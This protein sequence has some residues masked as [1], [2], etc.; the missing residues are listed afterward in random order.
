METFKIRDFTVE[1][2]D[3]Y[4]L[5]SCSEEGLLESLQ[6]YMQD[7]DLDLYWTDEE[8]DTIGRL[9]LD[10]KYESKCSIFLDV[11]D[12]KNVSDQEIS[13]IHLLGDNLDD[14]LKTLR[15]KNRYNN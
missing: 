8:T 7:N 13:L 3:Y 11:F 14:V 1:L 12:R 10:Y 9:Y 6:E 5:V 15:A 2:D 4:G